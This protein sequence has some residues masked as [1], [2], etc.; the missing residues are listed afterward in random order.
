[1]KKYLLPQNGNF[2]KANMHTHTTISDGSLSP[3]DTKKLYKTNGYSVVAFTDHDVFI[4]HP[5]LNDESFLALNGFEAE[6]TQED[7]CPPKGN[8]MLK[9]CHICFVAR[10]SGMETQP[11]FNPRYAIPGNAPKHV[12]KV[13][14]DEN[15]PFFIRSFSPES[16]N[17]MTKAASDAGFFVTYNHPTWSL[18]NYNDYTKYEN[19]NAMEIYNH[20]CHILGYDS[21]VPTIYDDMLKIG[22]KIYA[23]AADDIHGT[24]VGGFIMI[25]AEKL[26]YETITDALFAGNFYAS[27]GPEI[28]DLY[29]ED[30]KIHITCSDAA[31]ISMTTGGR[32]AKR[33]S[34]KKGNKINGAV[35]DL[36]KDTAYFKLSVKD[37]NGNFADTRAY[38]I[39]DLV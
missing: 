30:D 3:E 7:T 14:Y 29:I 5:E 6:F 33:I 8:K 2:Y 37:V 35:F 23:V 38:F 21:Y 26:E 36:D 4:T 15:V 39:E 19:L 18:E 11:C 22:K 24:S 10:S 32:S 25:K 28:F 27:N 9:T 1:M 13:K 12:D 31:D 17:E 16:I 34:A 20:E